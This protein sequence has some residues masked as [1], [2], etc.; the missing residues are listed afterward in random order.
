MTD[1]NKEY[2][3]ILF[4]SNNENI[5]QQKHQINLDPIDLEDEFSK[6]RF[7]F[8]KNI[9]ISDIKK[10]FFKDSNISMTSSNKKI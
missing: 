6:P 10:I 4:Q 1:L 8:S 9:I 2:K 7:T 3:P 5:R